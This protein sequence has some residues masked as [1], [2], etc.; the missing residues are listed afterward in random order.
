MTIHTHIHNDNTFKKNPNFTRYQNF[1]FS[2]E[3]KTSKHLF[4]KSVF[5]DGK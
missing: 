4:I 1:S 5:T 3:Y 2:L